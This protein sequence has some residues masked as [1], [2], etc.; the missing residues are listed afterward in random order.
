MIPGVNR[1][2][3]VQPFPYGP[4]FNQIGQWDWGAHGVFPT[5]LDQVNKPQKDLALDHLA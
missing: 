5:N 1:A 4:G 3:A 2:N